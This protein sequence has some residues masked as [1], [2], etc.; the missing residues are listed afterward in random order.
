MADDFRNVF[1]GP[2]VLGTLAPGFFATGAIEVANDEDIFAITLVAG[3]T[4]TFEAQGI[5]TAGF[6]LPDPSFYLRNATGSAVGFSSGIGG[7]STNDRL[8]FTVSS[9]GTYYVDMFGGGAVGTYRLTADAG[10]V[11]DFRDTYN[12]TNE[13][14]GTLAPGGTAT[15]KLEIAN[16]EDIFSI[17]LVAGRTYTFEAQGVSSGFTLADPSFYLRNA[18]G[19]PVGFSSG[20]GGGSTN[21]KLIFTATSSGTYYVDA[22][23][24][25][26]T[27]TYR[28]TADAGFVDDFRDT[29]NDTNEAL[30]AL[31]SGGLATGTLEIAN[32]EDIFAIS[33]VAGHSYTFTAQGV[34][35]GFT[36]ADPSFYLRN[37]TGA[38]VGFSASVGG[39]STNDTLTFN[40]TSSGTYY[41]DVFGAGGTGTYRVTAAEGGAVPDDYRDVYT[42]PAVP[43][44]HVLINAS[45]TGQIGTAGDKD[46]FAVVLLAGETYSFDLAR[47]ANGGT[48]LDNAYLSLLNGS[49]ALIYGNDNFNGTNAHLTYTATLS[50]T[51]YLEARSATLTGTGNYQVSVAAGFDDYR[52]VYNGLGPLGNLAVNSSR[53]GTIETAL[54]TD[55]FAVSLVA[56]ETYAFD[57]VRSTNGGAAL[58][59]AYLSLLNGTGGLIYANDNFSGTNSHLTYTATTTGTFYLEARSATATGTGNYQVFA[60]TGY[61]DY[62]DVYNGIG[63]LGQVPV[64]SS[65][66]GTIETAL[67]TDI[68]AVSLVAG[69]TYTFDL[70][71]STNGGAALDNAYLSL[72]N[73]SGGLLL[74]NDNFNATNARVT[75]TA[76]ST[77]T[78]YLEA[79]SATSVGTGNY[80]IIARAGF[81]DLADTITDP[82]SPL[83]V[84]AAGQTRLGTIETQGDSDVFRFNLVAGHNYTLHATGG[85]AAGMIHDSDLHLF[86]SA[87]TILAYNDDANN[88][89]NPE[90]HY[91]AA[92]TGTYYAEISGVKNDVG[93]YGFTLVEVL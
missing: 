50:G 32:D 45:S 13:A 14:L 3:V 86:D 77:G 75:Y 62:R 43:L 6:T 35:S 24:A 61:D 22:F 93:V 42:D 25:G 73:G 70:V 55:I 20:V 7:G 71:R 92:G 52:D 67:D 48:A 69:Q 9:T 36:L 12:D 8:I 18:T 49:G 56:G 40:A 29:Y 60:R 39:G 38:A 80:Q 33:L 63:T 58:D 21:D 51:F 65:R 89:L 10:F 11:D 87:G 46:V 72:F 88:S 28:I 83:G 64:N 81:D 91:T 26:G 44:G 19:S 34:S 85:V 53:Y 90:I 17:N 47:V 57:L 1:N 66:Y 78:F 68:F 2:G 76:S 59:N 84:I 74:A 54:D 15:G 23:G 27:G 31:A 16:D 30:G 82:A 41:V 79:R 37:A 5:F 4:Y